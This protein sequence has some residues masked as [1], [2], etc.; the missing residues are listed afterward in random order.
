MTRCIMIIQVFKI[1]N[2]NICV[3]SIS[4]LPADW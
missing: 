2:S 3:E 4:H 1:L